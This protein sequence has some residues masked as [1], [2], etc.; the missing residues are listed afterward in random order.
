MTGIKEFKRES[1]LYKVPV[2]L[3]VGYRKC[4]ASGQGIQLIAFYLAVYICAVVIYFARVQR[5]NRLIVAI[6]KGYFDSIPQIIF[7]CPGKGN[8]HWQVSANTLKTS[9]A[10][11]GVIFHSGG[12][13]WFSYLTTAKV[14][15][16]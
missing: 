3:I 15:A 9:T 13:H 2:G 5:V 4:I 1:T 10:P 12:E 8:G 16:T 14:R 7:V 11:A 6:I